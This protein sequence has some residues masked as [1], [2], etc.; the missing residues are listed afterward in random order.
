[1]QLS[2]IIVDYESGDYLS[3]CI[4]SL[5]EDLRQEL[6]EVIIID[7]STRQASRES[8]SELELALPNGIERVE[9][10][11][12][13]VNQGFAKACN[14]GAQRA[15]G[16]YL[17]FLNPDSEVKEGSL[18]KLIHKAQELPD[19]GLGG[20]LIRESFGGVQASA[21]KFPGAKTVFFG[22]SSL[23]S[24]FF[25][26]NPY[27]REELKSSKLE[28]QEEANPVDWV[29]GAALL[30]KRDVFFQLQGFDEH[31]FMYWEDA[32]LCFRAAKAKHKCYYIKTAEVVHHQGV[33]SDR[34]LW[35]SLFEFHRSVFYYY[36]KHVESRNLAYDFLVLSGLSLRFL[37]KGLGELI[38]I[39]WKGRERQE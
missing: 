28:D 5:D 24:K 20:P 4:R 29:S 2:V 34:S 6:C 1:M 26:N 18:E 11:E 19:F 35:T 33:C 3:R 14:Q 39:L 17:L 9:I 22:R 7:N 16:E 38:C 13:S 25:P 32:D 21:R 10:I 8:L 27:S 37:L 30:V 31:Y 23:L 15:K 12:S 36:C